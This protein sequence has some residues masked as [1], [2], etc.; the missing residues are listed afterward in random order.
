MRTRLAGTLVVIGAAFD[1]GC[2]TATPSAQPLLAPDAALTEVYNDDRFFEGPLWSPP[3]GKLYF[4]AFGKDGQ[5][6]LRLEKHGVA[7]VWMEE[8][9]GING[10][11]RTRDGRMLAAQAYGH[12]VLSLELGGASPAKSVTLAENPNWNQPND[13]CRAPNGDIYFTDPNFKDHAASA[14]YRLRAPLGERPSPA[15]RPRAGLS[16]QP[17]RIITDMAAPNGLVVSN[18][19]GTLFVGDSFHKHWRAY[20]I[21][22]NGTIGPGRVFF[23]PATDN[24]DD[25]DGMTI[26]ERGNLYF[27]GRGGIWI[28]RPDGTLLEFIRT[29]VF[30][31]NVCFGG[32][33]GR[34]LY[35]TGKGKVFAL[36]TNV[37]GVE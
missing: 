4:T 37:R 8:T 17:E 30:C 5:Q 10:T 3:E 20:P 7:H 11:C 35:I 6:I 36:Q 23:D 34:T 24:Q 28:V 13:V 15:D 1:S 9:E 21:A 14:V 2:G 19:G 31:S 29:P 25:P 32:A 26:D 18:D 16:A 12:R 22:A 27:T 33:N